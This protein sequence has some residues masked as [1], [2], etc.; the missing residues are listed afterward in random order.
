MTVHEL[1]NTNRGGRGVVWHYTGAYDVGFKGV[2]QGRKGFRILLEL[3][4]WMTTNIKTR[5]F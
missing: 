1:R 4:L 2:T 5:F 3:N